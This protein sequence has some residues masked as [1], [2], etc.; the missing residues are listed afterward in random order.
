MLLWL[1]YPFLRRCACKSITKNKN[2]VIKYVCDCLNLEK[3]IFSQ[4]VLIF[5][6]VIKPIESYDIEYSCFP[7]PKNG[8]IF[9]Y[10]INP[11]NVS[12]FAVNPVFANIYIKTC[13][14]MK[15]DL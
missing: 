15:Q 9:K 3:R 4:K 1:R 8:R 12:I 11:F 10:A 6:G 5:L 14:M 2:N 13:F 7:N